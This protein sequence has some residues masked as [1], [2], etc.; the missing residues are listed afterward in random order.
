MKVRKPLTSSC[1][2]YPHEKH[3]HLTVGDLEDKG[4]KAEIGKAQKADTWIA[5][6]SVT[7][8][9]VGLSER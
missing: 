4:F 7:H 5:L 6:Q 1:G 8:S 3:S 2:P 9:T